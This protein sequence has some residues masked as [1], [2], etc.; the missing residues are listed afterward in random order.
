MA[1]LVRVTT[2][3][4]QPISF[5]A[6]VW[7]LG[8]TGVSSNGQIKEFVVTDAIGTTPRYDRDKR[9]E[10][11]ENGTAT[12]GGF[13]VHG[14]ADHWRSITDGCIRMPDGDIAVFAGLVRRAG[15][16]DG[17]RTLIVSGKEQE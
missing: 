3:R 11:L 12:G 17:A 6:G 5:P 1:F 2:D 13:W 14:G 4:F 16:T 10:W 8:D 9:G 15:A 7:E